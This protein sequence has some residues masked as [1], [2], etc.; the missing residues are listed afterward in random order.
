[1]RG[2]LFIDKRGSVRIRQ[3][4]NGDPLTRLPVAGDLQDRRAG[5]PAMGKENAFAKDRAVISGDD[6]RHRHAGK[7]LDLLKQRLM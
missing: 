7:R 3:Q 2:A 5:E 4:V 6:R 1:M